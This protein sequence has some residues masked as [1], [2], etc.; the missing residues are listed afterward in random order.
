MPPVLPPA[1]RPGDRVG[2][3]AL[4]GPVD[5]ARLARGMEEIVRLGLVPVP[6]RNLASNSGLFAGEDGERVEAFHELADDP[7]LTAIF[8]ARGGHG[9]LRALPLIDWERLARHPRAYVGYSDLTPFLLNVVERLGWVAFHGPMV[10]AEM[11]RGLSEQE[12]RSLLQSLAGDLRQELALSRVVAGEEGAEGRLLGGCLSLLASVTGTAYATS[13]ADSVLFLEDIHE[14][15]YRVDR[16]LTQLYLS[17]SLK[18]I[19]AMVFGASML[20]V[21]DEATVA[22][23]RERAGATPAAFGLF[24]GHTTP[25]LT[26]PL[27]SSARLDAESSLLVIDYPQA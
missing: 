1:V 4:S 3:A 20:S 27:G 22:R 19:R 8:F 2:V 18:S 10:A 6:A 16:M 14:P 25:N 5:P 15:L 12:S 7:A 9:M 26:L 23:I 24:A 13:L 11:A 21:L 17:G